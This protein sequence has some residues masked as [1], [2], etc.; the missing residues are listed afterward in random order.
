MDAVTIVHTGA[1]L[2]MTAILLW[3]GLEKTRNLALTAATVKEIGF[4]SALAFPVA[5]LVAIAEIG[6]ALALLFRPDST[7]THAGVALLAGLFALAGLIAL[8]SGKQI[9]CLCFGAGGNGQLG[10]SQLIALI[11]WLA[12]IA[13]L[14]FGDLEAPS[15]SIGVAFL[16]ATCLVIASVRAVVVLKA[17]LEARGDRVSAQ[18][19]YRWLQ[20]R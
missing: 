13:L 16:A 5:L 1:A 15:F 20:S 2:I 10:K 18:E 17:L 19:M 8:R 7:V 6:V 11:G 9:R 4:S 12:G 3:A 14:R